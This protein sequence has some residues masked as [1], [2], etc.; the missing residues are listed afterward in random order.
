[1]TTT[2]PWFS[3]FKARDFDL[4][5]AAGP[6]R[7]HANCSKRTLALDLLRLMQALG[8][9]RFGVGALHTRR[10]FCRHGRTLAAFLQPLKRRSRASTSSW[11]R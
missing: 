3:G 6:V 4:A 1:M 9:D 10:S 2:T 11:V 8:H 5:G 7:I